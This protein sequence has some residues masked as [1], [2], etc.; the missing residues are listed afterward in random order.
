VTTYLFLQSLIDAGV[1]CGLPHLI[2]TQVAAQTIIGSMAVW[3]SRQALPTELI[4]EA[5]TPGG[6]SVKTLLMLKQHDFKAAVIDAIA[7]GAARANELGQDS[8]VPE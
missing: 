7:K 2:A 8:E 3:Q 4:S 5:S 1:G 6:V